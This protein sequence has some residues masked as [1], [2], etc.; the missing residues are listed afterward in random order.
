MHNVYHV[1]GLGPSRTSKQ[2]VLS[3]I[4]LISLV[5]LKNKKK[6]VSVDTAF[7]TLYDSDPCSPIILNSKT[8]V[9]L[10][11]NQKLN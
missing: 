3:L 10:G 9:G 2:N 4:L 6:G 7:C 8:N 11:P 1:C 5:K